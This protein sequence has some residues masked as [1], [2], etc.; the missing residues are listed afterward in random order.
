MK[1]GKESGKGKS[2]AWKIQ[3]IIVYIMILLCL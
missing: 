1:E 3:C 2:E